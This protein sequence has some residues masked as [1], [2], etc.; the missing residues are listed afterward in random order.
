[1]RRKWSNV[2]KDPNRGIKEQ[3][4]QKNSYWGMIN[5]LPSK[6]VERIVTDKILDMDKTSCD[7]ILQGILEEK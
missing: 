7:R 2:A 5:H 1:M 4:Q 6:G 3:M